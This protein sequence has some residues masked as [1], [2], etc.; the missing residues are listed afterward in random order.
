MVKSGIAGISYHG[1]D[2]MM[3]RWSN[4]WLALF[5]PL[6]AISLWLRTTSLETM[7]D[8]D[9]D[10]AWHAVQLTQDA[11]RRAVH[12]GDRDRP[13][14]EPDPRGHGIAPADDLRAVHGHPA[15][16][17]LITGIL[18]IVLAYV[19]GSRV[20]DRTTGMIAAGLIAV[21]PVATYCRRTGYESSHAPLFTL[22]LV[23]LAF[24]KNV[25]G[26]SI[27]LMCSYFVHPTNIFILPLLLAVMAARSIRSRRPR[28]PVA[29]T[30]RG[31]I[32]PTAIVVAIGLWTIQRPIIHKMSTVY[33][34]RDSRAARPPRV[35]GLL[36]T[37]LP[38]AGL[39]SW[40][41]ADPLFWSVFL[42]VLV[43]GTVRLV[44]GKQWDRVA[45]VAGVA[46]SAA[47]LFVV[48]GSKIMQP[49]MARYGYFL[50]VPTILAF[51]CL[52]RALL[53]TPSGRWSGLARSGQIAALLAMAGALQ[54][55]NRLD[56]V[57]PY[58]V[59]DSFDGRGEESPWTFGTDRQD[60][61]KQAFSYVLDDMARLGTDR[62][63]IFTVEPMSKSYFR[64]LALSHPGIEVLSYEEIGPEPCREAISAVPTRSTRA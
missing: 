42:V 57:K 13:A 37:A 33:A 47:A 22:L 26:M 4:I 31:A 5:L 60:P 62:G 40:P 29:A 35:P 15:N 23:Y 61:R 53:V 28:R 25:L 49:G 46:A 54:M 43:L 9:G 63:V 58:R 19:L 56:L 48:G 11:P 12:P 39:G 16:P 17:V 18:A 55:S 20:L 36:R 30:G 2:H 1:A 44:R 34:V 8:I 64:L 6:I 38:G 3:V 50:V 27:L 21:L 10:E 24:R 52:I 51:A 59:V 45:L 7:P 41:R 14:A 32:P